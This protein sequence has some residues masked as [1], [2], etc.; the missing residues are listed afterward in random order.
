VLLVTCAGVGLTALLQRVEERF[1]SW[2]PRLDEES[3]GT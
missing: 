1:S 3:A 2:R